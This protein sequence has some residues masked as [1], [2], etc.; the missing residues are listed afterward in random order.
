MSRAVSLVMAMT[1]KW[2][3]KISPSLS[4]SGK[5]LYKSGHAHD[6]DA[7]VDVPN[8][9]QID[10]LDAIDDC[11]WNDNFLCIRAKNLRKTIK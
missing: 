3:L 9:D 2:M 11:F 10:L 1:A 7:L 5:I 8:N 4:Q 6:H